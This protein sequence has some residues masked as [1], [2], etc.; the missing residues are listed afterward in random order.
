MLSAGYLYFRQWSHYNMRT[1]E[2]SYISEKE[3]GKRAFNAGLSAAIFTFGICSILGAFSAEKTNENAIKFFIVGIYVSPLV[4]LGTIFRMYKD[5]EPFTKMKDDV[6]F[7]N[8]DKD[9]KL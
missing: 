8:K 2:Y 1:R 6:V 4:M 5:L 9:R 7:L 3:R